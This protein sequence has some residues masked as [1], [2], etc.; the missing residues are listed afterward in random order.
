MCSQ[1]KELQRIYPG[2]TR[3]QLQKIAK[4]LLNS[5]HPLLGNSEFHL[6]EAKK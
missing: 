1:L 4:V 2:A 5:S 3:E 6:Y